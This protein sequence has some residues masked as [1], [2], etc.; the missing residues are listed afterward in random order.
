MIKTFFFD[1]ETTGLK[2]WRN[3][4]H[5]ISGIIDIDGKVE[6]TFDIKVR[7]NP[8][9][10]IEDEALAVCGK[11]KEEILAY[12]EMSDG[13][14]QL[15]SILGKYVDKYNKQD[16]MFL[17]GYNN[18]SFD[19]AFLRAFFVQNGDDYFG[20]WFWSSALDVM[21]LAAEKLRHMRHE[22]GSF[23][24]SSVADALGIAVDENMRHDAIYDIEITRQ[25][26]YKLR[27]YG[28]V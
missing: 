11:T 25:V 17:A 4:I 22:M 10:D 20:S 19:N 15:T 26:Y 14:Q 6:E 3:G 21:V 7:P 9:A 16:K 1:L 24:L 12:P 27:E 23:K 5:Q 8:S 2:Y 18:A 28:R 13:Y